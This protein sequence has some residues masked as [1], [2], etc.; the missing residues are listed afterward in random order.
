[1]RHAGCMQDG[2]HF[3]FA[4][5]EQFEPGR[6]GRAVSLVHQLLGEPARIGVRVEFAESDLV[7]RAQRVEHGVEHD[8]GHAH[9]DEVVHD[10]GVQGG[11]GEIVEQFLLSGFHLVGRL[12][13]VGAQVHGLGVR[14]AGEVEIAGTVHVGA[15]QRGAAV[16]AVLGEVFVEFFEVSVAVHRGEHDLSVVEQMRAALEHAVEL[17]L[18]D[19]YDPRVRPAGVFLR[20][21][22][23]DRHEMTVL[24]ILGDVGAALLAN[25][26]DVRFPGI[27]EIDI[28]VG[29]LLQQ[30]AILDAHSTCTNHR[31]LHIHAPSLLCPD[32]FV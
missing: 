22:D 5:A 23:V 1:M 6:L 28:L 15:D 32:E 16:D 12:V 29:E 3:A 20:I 14:A 30:H 4:C 25:L 10:G 18:L 27:D 11:R 19:E 9:A 26:L 7:H 8:L 13:R 2:L 24:A 17:H 21:V 31:V